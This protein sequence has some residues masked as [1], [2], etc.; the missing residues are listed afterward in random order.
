MIKTFHVFG[1]CVCVHWCYRYQMN[2]GSHAMPFLIQTSRTLLVRIAFEMNSISWHRTS[3]TNQIFYY[4]QWNWLADESKTLFCTPKVSTHMAVACMEDFFY[5]A[6]WVAKWR[7]EQNKRI[8]SILSWKSTT[9]KEKRCANKS[10]EYKIVYTAHTL[11]QCELKLL[12]M[13]TYRR[14]DFTSGNISLT[15]WVYWCIWWPPKLRANI[16]KKR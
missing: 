7:L 2:Y 12:L 15:H 9:M 4:F 8:N 11:T 16:E 6:L 1:V 3:I 13:Q 10:C 14:A 5:G